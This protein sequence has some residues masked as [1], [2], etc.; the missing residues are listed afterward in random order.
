MRRVTTTK[1][2][3]R[4]IEMVVMS[5]NTDHGTIYTCVNSSGKSNGIEKWFATQGEALASNRN[6]IDFML[7]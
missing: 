5:D 4:G 7:H 3:Y 2:T 6:D 1:A